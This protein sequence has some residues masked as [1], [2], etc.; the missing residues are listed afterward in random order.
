[1][2]SNLTNHKKGL[3]AEYVAII[4]LWCKGYRIL[5]HRYKTKLGEIDIIAQHKNTLV[6]IEVKLRPTIDDALSAIL[7]TA[8]KRIINALKWYL[9]KHSNIR[10]ESIRCDVIAVSKFSIHHLDNAWQE[11]HTI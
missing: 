5:H 2:K 1:M 9:S 7:P 8:R 11:T 4:Y 6:A 10:T 3:Y